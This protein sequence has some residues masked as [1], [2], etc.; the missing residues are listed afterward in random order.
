MRSE[1][2]LY[3]TD[4]KVGLVTL[5]RPDKLN[6]L[7]MDLRLIDRRRYE[8]AARGLDEVGRLVGG[9]RKAHA[10]AGSA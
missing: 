2:V 3:E 8:Y 1:I 7:S 5:N 9:W 6:A 4:G 10:A